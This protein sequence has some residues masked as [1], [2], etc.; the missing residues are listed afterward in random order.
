MEILY[1]IQKVFCRSIIQ[2][3][4]RGLLRSH[5]KN[6]YS[7]L[8]N[9]WGKIPEMYELWFDTDGGEH[10]TMR[11]DFE[12]VHHFPPPP[13]L[14]EKVNIP[15]IVNRTHFFHEELAREKIC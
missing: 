4:P 14:V 2:L 10:I 13:G 12:R 3:P 7:C 6:R 8:G 5:S 9:A 11:V 15:P 1:G